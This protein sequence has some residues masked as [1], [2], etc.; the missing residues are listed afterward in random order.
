MHYL[1]SRNT[2]T[3]F[4]SAER[5]RTAR[6]W[7]YGE[8]VGPGLV[9]PRWLQR[10]DSE[11]GVLETADGEGEDAARRAIFCEREMG[12]QTT[13]MSVSPSRFTELPAE[14]SERILLHLPGQDII[15]MEAVWQTLVCDDVV[16]TFCRMAE[17]SRY[18]LDLVH[19]SPT[20]QYRRELFS[21]GLTDYTLHPRG[22]AERRMLCKEHVDKWTGTAKVVRRV[23]NVPVG[24]Q[25]NHG[26]ALGGDLLALHQS[27]KY[28]CPK[29]L[30]V[31][32]AVSQ[33]SVEGWSV[34]RLPF[35]VSGF[36]V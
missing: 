14:V 5:D 24:P 10:S 2:G 21:A 1:L 28:D 9:G 20:L 23:Y 36:A 17:V 11:R 30:R 6:G 34:P 16:L 26:I 19:S 3:G 22:L 27:Y 25:V 33:R 18:F 8:F 13:V 32:P 4:S 12:A 15:K 7:T 31:P 29:F 35:E